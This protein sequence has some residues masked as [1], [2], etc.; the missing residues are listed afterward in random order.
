MGRLPSERSRG[1]FGFG[2][3]I[4]TISASLFFCLECDHAF[5]RVKVRG[6]LERA[7][8]SRA[9]RISGNTDF[10]LPEGEE[11]V[12][13]TESG[14]SLQ[15][16]PASPRASGFFKAHF[17]SPLKNKPCPVAS[18]SRR[19]SVIVAPSRRR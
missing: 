7:C 17:F 4:R 19:I 10:P 16:L 5:S 14:Y 1:L 13:E 2:V 12:I 3:R 6:L 9:L 11:G 8:V 18:G 15:P